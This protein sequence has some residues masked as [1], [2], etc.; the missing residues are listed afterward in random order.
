MKYPDNEKSESNLPHRLFTNM[1]WCLHNI[2]AHPVSEIF[3]WIGLRKA[4]N[5]IHDATIPQHPPGTGRG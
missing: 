3:W 2:V 5:W 1:V 4:S